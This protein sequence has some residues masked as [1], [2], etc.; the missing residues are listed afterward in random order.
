MVH[1]YKWSTSTKGQRVKKVKE[2]KVNKYKRS[3]TTKGKRDQK[4]K[5]YKRLM[6]KIG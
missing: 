1:E 3:K 6:S 2:Y 4:A 5:E